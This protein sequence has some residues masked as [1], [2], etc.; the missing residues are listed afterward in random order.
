MRVLCTGSI[1]WDYLMTFPGYFHEHILPDRLEKISVS[2]LVDGM[3]RQRGGIG[4]NIAYTLA[5][6]GGDAHLLSTVGED[7]TDYRAWLEQHGVHTEHA[8]VIAGTFTASFFC[9]TDRN[10]AQIASFFPG[11]MALAGVQSLHDVDPLPDLVVISPSAPDAMSKFVKEARELGIRYLYDPS[12]QLARI[13]R[14]E[15]IEGV[16]SAWMLVVNDYEAGL[17]EKMTSL[18]EEQLAAKLP[19]LV[20]TRGAEGATIFADGVRTDIVAVAPKE[21][22]DPTGVGDAFRGGLLRGV[23]AGWPWAL[24]GQ[25]ASLAATYCLEKN[26]PQNHHYSQAEFLTRFRQHFDDG[27]LLSE[28]F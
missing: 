10:N 18:S 9:N 14:E 20:I 16:D 21:I 28:L 13:T 22:V 19:V 6:L 27:G 7:F 25:V 15:L 12:Q 26:G 2:F 1:A 4:P 3:T 5:L 8:K 24:C 11:A 17:I 23:A